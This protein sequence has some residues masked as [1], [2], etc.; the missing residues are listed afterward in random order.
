MCTNTKLIRNRWTGRTI[1]VKC[2]K[3]PACVQQKA[4]ARANRIRN[5]S[6]YGYIALFVTLTYANEFIPYVYRHNVQKDVDIP[7]YRDST[8]RLLKSGIFKF[9]PGTKVVDVINSDFDDFGN[10][11]SLCKDLKNYYGRIGVCY[12]PDLQDFLKRLRINLQ[13]HY[14]INFP[15]SYFACS[16]Y[17]GRSYRPHFHLL[18]FVPTHYVNEVKSCIYESWPYDYRGT[19]RLSVEVARNAASYVSSYVNCSSS[20]PPFLQTSPIKQKHSYSQNFG[21]Y[22]ECFTLSSILEK[23]DKRDLHYYREIEGTPFLVISR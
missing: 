16:E 6:R 4:A 3:C 21:V 12:Y 20:F 5:S 10:S 19:K 13:R 14:E 1:R 18:I 17:G 9:N 11:L 23:T 22:M 8:A 2:G 15:L 7:I